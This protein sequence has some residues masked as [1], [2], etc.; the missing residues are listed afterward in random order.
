MAIVLTA[1]D[2]TVTGVPDVTLGLVKKMP[3]YAAGGEHHDHDQRQ[4]AG[5]DRDGP[6]AHV[7]DP[8]HRGAGEPDQVGR[9]ELDL[10]SAT[11]RADVDGLESGWPT[12]R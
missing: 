2:G 10:Q 3:K 7:G 12:R 4:D 8:G 5:G 9:V 1:A 11:T 6:A